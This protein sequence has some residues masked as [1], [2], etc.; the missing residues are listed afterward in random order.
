MK[1]WGLLSLWFKFRNTS[2]RWRIR[3]TLILHLMPHSS[4]IRVSHT[5]RFLTATWLTLK[6]PAPL[7]LCWT[8]QIL[9]MTSPWWIPKPSH[10]PGWGR[11]PAL[12]GCWPPAERHGSH[13]VWLRNH[14]KHLVYSSPVH[15]SPS[16][17]FPA[18]SLSDSALK[19]ITFL[20]STW[21]MSALTLSYKDYR[22]T[23]FLLT[24]W[25]SLNLQGNEKG[26]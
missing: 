6:F 16:G 22:R 1:R 2:G 9:T 19:Y 5:D 3:D 13:W 17:G 24:A 26:G 4:L 10:F 21:E 14:L 18:S 11:W 20:F 25:F 15:C 23:N 8:V 12:L 7:C